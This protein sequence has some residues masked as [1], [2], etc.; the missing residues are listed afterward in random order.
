MPYNYC[1]CTS[2]CFYIVGRYTY[3]SRISSIF[4]PDTPQTGNYCSCTSSHLYI[5]GRST[6]TSW[7]FFCFFYKYGKL[8]KGCRTHSMI[9]DWTHHCVPYPQVCPVVN[10][11]K[12]I[13]L[14]KCDNANIYLLLHF[15]QIHVLQDIMDLRYLRYYAYYA[16]N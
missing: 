14:N 5:V 7:F 3:T 12:T 8:F 10:P 2:S 13:S 6:C 15:Q 1:S 16:F 11:Y 4:M 9:Y